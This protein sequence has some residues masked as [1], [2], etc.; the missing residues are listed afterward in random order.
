MGTGGTG[1]GIRIRIRFA[2]AFGNS[3]KVVTKKSSLLA[4]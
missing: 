2:P 1:T 4:V 3:G